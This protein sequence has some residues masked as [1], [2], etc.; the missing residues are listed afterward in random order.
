VA[1]IKETK[2]DTSCL[3]VSVRLTR[4]EVRRYGKLSGGSH[5]VHR[6]DHACAEG[7]VSAWDTRL[8]CACDKP[9][10]PNFLNGIFTLSS[11]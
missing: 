3:L 1:G 7:P 4:P 8:L 10:K 6:S 11:V 5:V 2:S 9:A